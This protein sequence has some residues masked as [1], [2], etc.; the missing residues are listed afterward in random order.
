MADEIIEAVADSSPAESSPENN[1]K[2]SADPERLLEKTKKIVDETSRRFTEHTMA[3][4]QALATYLTRPRDSAQAIKDA[5]D[6]LARHQAVSKLLEDAIK[7]GDPGF[8]ETVFRS[9][10][11]LLHNPPSADESSGATVIEFPQRPEKTSPATDALP[12]TGT[13][14]GKVSPTST[15]VLKR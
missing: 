13:G 8:V 7:T 3:E 14:G 2:K 12:N 9:I 11:G 1:P 5:A 10:P 15:P 6:Q 4:A